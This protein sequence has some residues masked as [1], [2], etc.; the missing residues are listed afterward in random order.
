MA[1]IKYFFK[2]TSVMM[3]MAHGTLKCN[4]WIETQHCEHTMKKAPLGFCDSLHVDNMCTV[5]PKTYKY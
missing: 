4:P 1:N 3:F 2:W 5:E